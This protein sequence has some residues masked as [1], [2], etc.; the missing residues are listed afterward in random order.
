M[1]SGFTCFFSEFAYKAEGTYTI[2]VKKFH[3]IRY[4][5]H[6][7]SCFKWFVMKIYLILVVLWKEVDDDTLTQ[8]SIME[9]QAWPIQAL[10]QILK[11]VCEKY[12]MYA[13]KWLYPLCPQVPK[14]KLKSRLKKP[15]SSLRNY[16]HISDIHLTLLFGFFIII[17]C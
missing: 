14:T 7:V 3:M 1:P 2:V 8:F 16:F 4:Q 11:L 12:H 5:N 10:C 13:T 9:F 17:I 6:M 15:S